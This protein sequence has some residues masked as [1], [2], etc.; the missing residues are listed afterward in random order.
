MAQ[1]NERMQLRLIPTLLPRPP[2][3]DGALLC[4]LFGGKG[5]GGDGWRGVL[6]RDLAILSLAS[7]LFGFNSFLV[8]DVVVGISE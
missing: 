3:F 1:T 6:A 8:R 7:G 5:D 4:K 2:G